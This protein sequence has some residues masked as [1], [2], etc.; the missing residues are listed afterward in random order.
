MTPPCREI[1]HGRPWDSHQ[2]IIN[3]L[4]SHKTYAPLLRNLWRSNDDCGLGMMMDDDNGI[5][6]CSFKVGSMVL[7]PLSK[8]IGSGI[9]S[10]NK[11]LCILRNH[12][13]LLRTLKWKQPHKETMYHC[14]TTAMM[15]YWCCDSH[16]RGNLPGDPLLADFLNTNCYLYSLTILWIS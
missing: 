16:G 7:D 12:C 6:N 3:P 11:C 13:T 10:F 2:K 15:D 4:H 5:I 14:I 8:L 1:L 9:S